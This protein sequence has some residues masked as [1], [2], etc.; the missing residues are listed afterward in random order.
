MLAFLG[1]IGIFC[2]T[3]MVRD[4]YKYFVM[5]CVGLGAIGLLLK[6]DFLFTIPF[7][8]LFGSLICLMLMGG[9][10]SDYLPD[11]GVSMSDL[12]DPE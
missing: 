2:L 8:V 4:V 5:I 6:I 7:T 1:F 11:R 3:V 10:S 12:K 9:S